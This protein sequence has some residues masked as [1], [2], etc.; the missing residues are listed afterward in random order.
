MKWLYTLPESVKFAIKEERIYFTKS[1]GKKPEKQQEVRCFK[2]QGE[3]ATTGREGPLICD[4]CGSKV[5]ICDICK[6][7][8]I[9]GQKIMQVKGCEHL[10]HKE[11]IIEWINARGTCP[12]CKENINEES[13]IPYHP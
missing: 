8:I 1:V 10:F 7:L 11:H 12:L 9:A 2:C 4:N 3:L 5:P 13:L 6:N